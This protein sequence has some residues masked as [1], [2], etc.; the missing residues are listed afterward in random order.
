VLS[1]KGRPRKFYAWLNQTSSK[2]AIQDER[3]LPKYEHLRKR[4]YKTRDLAP[5]DVFNDIKAFY[6]RTR[7]HGYL[8]GVSSKAFERTSI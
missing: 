4:I 3:T 6:N 8:G 1:V 7:R 5:A 2:R